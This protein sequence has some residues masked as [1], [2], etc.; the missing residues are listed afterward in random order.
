MAPLQNESCNASTKEQLEAGMQQLVFLAEFL[1]LVRP[2]EETC[3]KICNYVDTAL[4][5][6]SEAEQKVASHL[7]LVDS[8]SEALITVKK[9]MQDNLREKQ[10]N[11]VDLK[12][13]TVALQEAEEKSR[14]MLQTAELYLENTKERLKL[15]HEETEKN[16][17]GREIGMHLMILPGLGTIIGAGVLLGYQIALES[18]ENL[19][20]E[21]QQAVEE[22]T[23]EVAGFHDKI[24]HFSQKEQKLKD[25]IN[26]MNQKIIQ[27]QVQCDELLAFQG[28]VIMKQSWIRKCLVFLDMLA[29]KVHAAAVMSHHAFIPE[30]LVDILGDIAQ[31]MGEKGVEA[32]LENQKIQASV[33]E[34]SKAVKTL[35]SRGGKSTLQDY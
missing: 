2:D 25:G 11:L 29:G 12:V 7:L 32:F 10:K 5:Y 13:Q 14:G 26:A 8:Q 27:T 9:L 3:V 20:A 31:V 15:A 4:S 19:V 17:A 30:L 18:A 28:D 16:R 1:L 21:A 33:L 34:I 6:F 22:Y 35:K 24:T 23:T